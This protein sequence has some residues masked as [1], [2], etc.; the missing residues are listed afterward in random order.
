MGSVGYVGGEGFL[1][2]MEAVVCLP[3]APRIQLS[4]SAS[5]G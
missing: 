2:L 4:V 3:A 5:N 1:L